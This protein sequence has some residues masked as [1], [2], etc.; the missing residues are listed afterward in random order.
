VDDSKLTFPIP[1][2]ITSGNVIKGWLWHPKSRFK[3]SSERAKWLKWFKKLHKGGISHFAIVTISR[4]SPRKIDED[5]LVTGCKMVVDA[6]VDAEILIDDG[7]DW[8]KIKYR[9][10]KCRRDEHKTLV[11]VEYVCGIVIPTPGKSRAAKTVRV[12]DG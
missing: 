9:Q 8:V 3:Y 4:Y 6:M 10:E 2:R 7:P 1:L 5:N 11:E 12:K